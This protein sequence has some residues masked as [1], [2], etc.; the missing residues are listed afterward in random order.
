M[1]NIQANQ[2]EQLDQVEQP[3]QQLVQPVKRPQGRPKLNKPPKVPK[4][5][6]RPVKYPGGTRDYHRKHIKVEKN[7]YKELIENEKKYFD[8]LKVNNI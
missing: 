3:E 5:G 7:R 6:G 2:E 4:K 8:L 1:E